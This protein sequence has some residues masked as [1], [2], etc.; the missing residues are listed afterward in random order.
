MKTKVWYAIGGLSG[1]GAE[2]QVQMIAENL[3]RRRFQLRICHVVQSALDPVLPKH[4]QRNHIQR[5]RAWKWGRVWREVKEDL[6]RFGPDVV[7]TWLPA[8]ITL[9]AAW[10]AWRMGVPTLTSIRRSTFKGIIAT[11]YPKEILGI[12]PHFMG[13]K[14]VANFPIE[15]EPWPVRLICRAKG[16]AMVPNGV[17][18][19]RMSHKREEISNPSNRALKLLYVG[20]FAKQKRLPFLVKALYRFQR[21][22]RKDVWLDV[23]GKGTRRQEEKIAGLLSMSDGIGSR[24]RLK[25][26][27]P[28][29][30]RNA[31]E[32]DYLVMPSV[33][34]GMPNAVVEA[35]VEGLPSIVSG[36]PEHKHVVDELISGFYFKPD[37]EESFCDA[38]SKAPVG[39]QKWAEISAGARHSAERFSA[40]SM[41]RSY[42]RIYEDLGAKYGKWRR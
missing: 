41:V 12:L 35:Q 29:W 33:S 15:R 30:R 40:D 19:A 24:I 21:E 16:F 1:G 8:V 28:D 27:V 26:Y 20:R 39:N 23:C 37:D 5:T 10:W 42:E 17:D 31:H 34:E 4:V 38:L 18:L 6:Q 7:H 13:K 2:R 11:D 3:D 36:I 14:V 25:G 22:Y 9:P 32:Y